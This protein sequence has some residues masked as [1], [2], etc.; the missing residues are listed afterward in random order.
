[1]QKLLRYVLANFE[2][3][4]GVIL[5]VVMVVLLTIQ[6]ISR[7]V[8][9]NALPW[10]EE[11][12]VI[13]FILSVYFGASLAVKRRQH[14]RL[15]V[16]ANLFNKRIQKIIR[17]VANMIFMFFC[18]Y[19]SWFLLLIIEKLY[20]SNNITAVTQIPKVYIYI[21]LPLLLLST[22]VRLIQDSI[23]TVREMKMETEGV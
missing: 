15:Q 10:S 1:M 22:T 20:H 21:F 4:I 16:F 5:S 13:C 14:L 2:R 23:K 6:V 11:L 17:V 7:Y 3:D 9:G 8:F 18:C 19:M 12:A